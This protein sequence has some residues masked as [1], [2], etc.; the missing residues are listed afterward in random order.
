MN[1]S[2]LMHGQPY[3][4]QNLKDWLISEKLNGCRAAWDGDRMWTRSGREILLPDRW[5][6][7]LPKLA[8]DGEIYSGYGGF[9]AASAA[10]R[11]GK[12]IPEVRYH[13][14]DSFGRKSYPERLAAA[15]DAIAGLE[16]ASPVLFFKARNNSQVFRELVLVQRLGGEGLI[17]RSPAPGPYL[18]GRTRDILKLKDP[19]RFL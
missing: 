6:G 5:R 12:F 7:G 2:D 8:L 10:V 13:V 14:F 1:D 18:A 4:G 17:A 9:N 16:F 15:A 11:F 19:V 3:D